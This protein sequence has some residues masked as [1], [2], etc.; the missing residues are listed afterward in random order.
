MKLSKEKRDAVKKALLAGKAA[1]K[2]SEELKV[3]PKDVG[4]YMRRL[5]RIKKRAASDHSIKTTPA[6]K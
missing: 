1:A 3:A 5:D 4:R 6:A 2:I